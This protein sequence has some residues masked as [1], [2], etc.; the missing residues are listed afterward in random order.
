MRRLGRLRCRGSLKRIV[1][2]WVTEWHVEDPAGEKFKDEAREV[3]D[4]RAGGR[5]I[6]VVIKCV[7]FADIMSRQH[8]GP[9]Y[10]ELV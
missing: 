3:L 7:R 10:E 2:T 9:I 5:E 6:E 1:V 8:P 4:R